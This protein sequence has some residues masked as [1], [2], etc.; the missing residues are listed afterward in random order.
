M[1]S[2]SPIALNKFP[3]GETPAAFR[4]MSK[5]QHIGKIVIEVA[6]PRVEVEDDLDRRPVSTRA[7]AILSLAVCA[8]FG[9]AVADWLSRSGAGR[10]VLVSRRN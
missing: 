5:A 3:V 6:Q 9:V 7:R 1:A 8:G 2:T 10:V 4:M